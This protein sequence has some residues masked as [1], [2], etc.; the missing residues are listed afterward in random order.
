MSSDCSV[1][2][3]LSNSD[4]TKDLEPSFGQDLFSTEVDQLDLDDFP[5]IA[6]TDGVMSHPNSDPNFRLE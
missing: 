5:R 1:G 4:F 2:N 3:E 6:D